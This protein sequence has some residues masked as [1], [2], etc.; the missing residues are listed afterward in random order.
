MAPTLRPT[1]Y[2]E[3][4]LKQTFGTAAAGAGAEAPAGALPK[5][6]LNEERGGKERKRFLSSETVLAQYPKHEK[7]MDFALG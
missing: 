2:A 4:F 3:P 1:S 7:P 6:T 5:K